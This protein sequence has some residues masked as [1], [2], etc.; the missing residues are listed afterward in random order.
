MFEHNILLGFTTL[1]K[2]LFLIG[3]CKF[4]KTVGAFLK[5]IAPEEGHVVF[6]TEDT[7]IL[8]TTLQSRV[9]VVTWFPGFVPP[10]CT[11]LT[12]WLEG[13]RINLAYLGRAGVH[14]CQLT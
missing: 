4:S 7:Q 14:K 10:G 11:V 3:I 5:F 6:H 9:T 1:R 12:V 8:C 13:G 2:I